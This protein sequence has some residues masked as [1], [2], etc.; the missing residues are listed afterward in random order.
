MQQNDPKITG[1]EGYPRHH[2]MW[3][4]ALDTARF[5]QK[6]LVASLL[7][8]ALMIVVVNHALRKPT[9]VVRVDQLGVATPIGAFS[10]ES[11]VTKPEVVNF[12]KLYLEYFLE[13]SFY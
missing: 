7:L 3:G 8:N 10:S 6:A 11:R 13:R 1:G 2:E 9:I 5:L 12:T 4:D